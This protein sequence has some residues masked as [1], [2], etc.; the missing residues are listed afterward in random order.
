M[1][2]KNNESVL[3][4]SQC[5]TRGQSPQMNGLSATKHYFWCYD[6]GGH[7]ARVRQLDKE[8]TDDSHRKQQRTGGN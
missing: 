8:H 2:T 7:T 6:V 4:S 3:L 5:H 1:R